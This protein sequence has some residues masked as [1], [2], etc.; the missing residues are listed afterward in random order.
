MSLLVSNSSDSVWKS[1]C[2]NL[3]HDLQC[4]VAKRCSPVHVCTP[5]GELP[6]GGDAQRTVHVLVGNPTTETVWLCKTLTTNFF[7]VEDSK[8]AKNIMKRHQEMAQDFHRRLWPGVDPSSIRSMC[9]EPEG[10][11]SK[12][13]LLSCV[14]TR[15]MVSYVGHMMSYQKRSPALRFK[16]F[17]LLKALVDAVA[18]LNLTFQFL[19]FDPEGQGQWCQQQLRAGGICQPWRQDF[20]NQFLTLTWGQDLHNHDKMWVTSPSTYVHLAD[21]IAFA[22]D[23]PPYIHRKVNAN[24]R[25]AKQCLERTALT[26]LTQMAAYIQEYAVTLTGLLSQPNRPRRRTGGQRLSKVQK[27]N[28]V[29]AALQDVLARDATCCHTS[30]KCLQYVACLCLVR[31]MLIQQQS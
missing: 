11:D 25:W 15:L 31:E 10:V 4:S 24:L 3:W 16:A 17:Q 6:V 26:I 14:D 20:F 19:H 13:Y 30:T 7:D 23:H 22:L 28:I 8:K 27:W 5:Q 2:Q 18:G 21:F 1:T 29:A 12:D 9:S